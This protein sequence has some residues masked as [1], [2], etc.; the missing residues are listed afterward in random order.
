MPEGDAVVRTARR[1]DRAL[2][3]QLLTATDF[4]VPRF[5]VADLLVDLYNKGTDAGRAAVVTIAKE[6][7]L[8]YGVW[9]GLSEDERAAV[10]AQR[11]R[12]ERVG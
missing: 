12:A 2:Q 9:G 4:R 8:N 6:A 1:L 7:P 5:A 10:L 11:G 3:G